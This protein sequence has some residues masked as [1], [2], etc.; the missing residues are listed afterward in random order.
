MKQVN[1]F[2]R[3]STRCHARIRFFDITYCLKYRFSK[4]D[5]RNISKIHKNG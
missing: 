4:R 3:L 1:L 2:G 5:L